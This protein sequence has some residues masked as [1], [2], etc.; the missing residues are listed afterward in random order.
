MIKLA[1]FED[2]MPSRWRV[3][4][5]LPEDMLKALEKWAAAEHRSTSNLAASILINAIRE[6]EQKQSPPPEGKGN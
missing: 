2:S 1:S 3:T 6:R 4:V 5:T